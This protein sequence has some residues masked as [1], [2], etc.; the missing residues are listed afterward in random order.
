MTPSD[1][2]ACREGAAKRSQGH[3]Q[4][5]LLSREIREFGVPTLWELWKAT[6]LAALSRAVDGPRAVEEPVH[7]RN[8]HA[9]EPG[10]P[11][12]AL[13]LITSGAAQ[14]TLRRYA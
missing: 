12:V 14:G 1:A 7:V 13:W 6:S 9:R 10:D 4:A 5:G 8:L 3:V 2:L 11:T